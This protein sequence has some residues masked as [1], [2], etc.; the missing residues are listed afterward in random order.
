ML[1]G[2]SQSIEILEGESDA[3]GMWGLVQKSDLAKMLKAMAPKDHMSM[4]KE[5]GMRCFPLALAC[6]VCTA[7]GFFSH[8]P[9]F[10]RHVMTVT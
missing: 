8:Y 5:A 7:R 2:T 6:T 9:G 4:A 1:H 10:S 3:S